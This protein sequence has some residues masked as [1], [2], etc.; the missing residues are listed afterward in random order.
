ME[1]G[2]LKEKKCSKSSLV[3]RVKESACR[4]NVLLSAYF[5]L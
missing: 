4:E 5:L 2:M 3:E 1:I